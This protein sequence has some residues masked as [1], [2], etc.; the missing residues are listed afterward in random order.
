[1]NTDPKRDFGNII[2]TTSFPKYMSSKD[3]CDS[4]DF[5]IYQDIGIRKNIFSRLFR[6]FSE[7]PKYFSSLIPSH[8][9]KVTYILHKTSQ[10][11]FLVMTEKNIFAY[12]LFLSLNISDF[13]L[14]FMWQLQPP[15][16]KFT[17]SFPATPL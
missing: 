13:N 1:M 5:P 3:Y 9:L 8:L 7:P 2:K 14:F 6:Y 11:E 16:K 12:E 15:L 17:S 4:N 10:F